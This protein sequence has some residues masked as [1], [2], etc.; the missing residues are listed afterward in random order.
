MTSLSIVMAMYALVATVT[1]PIYITRLSILWSALCPTHFAVIVV[2]GVCG[3]VK[4]HCLSGLSGHT[5]RSV[6]WAFLTLHGVLTVSV[7]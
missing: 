6:E 1:L 5:I 4:G 3:G 2:L 7:V